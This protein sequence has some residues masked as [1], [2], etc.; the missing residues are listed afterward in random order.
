MS[1]GVNLA[2]EQQ[3][4]IVQGLNQ[5]LDW[6]A[7]AIEYRLT[8]YFQATETGDILVQVPAPPLSG[9]Y[10]QLLRPYSLEDAE[11][12]LLILALAPHLRPEILDTFFVK[13]TNLDRPF[14]EFGGLTSS[15]HQGFLPTA[16][17][18]AFLLA[19]TDLNGRLRTMALLR[20]Q[21]ALRRLQLL[22]L[23]HPAGHEP[24]L[25]ASLCVS[26]D[27][28]QL[29]ITG[30]RNMP[31]YNMQFPAKRLQSLLSWNDLILPV[32]VMQE[33]EHILGWLQHQQQIMGHWQLSRNISP[34]YR[35]LFYGPP[36]TGKTLTAT[37]IGQRA[38]A[39]VY[40]IDLSSLVSKYI[41][42][43]EKNLSTLFDQA[44]ARNW[45][46]FFDEADALFGKRTA[47]HSSHDRYANQE[48][49]YLLQRIEDFPGMVILA[50]NLKV[51][52]DEAFARRFQ[53]LLYFPLPE[54]NERLR[55]WQQ[56]LSGPVQLAQDV[57]IRQLAFEHEVSGGAIT[58][59]V[60]YA[61]I[62]ALQQ[63]SERIRAEDLLQGINR[64]KRKEG[65]MV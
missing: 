31:D 45:I 53:S 50:S 7:R 23:Q 63:G 6:L 9:D 18:A 12:L 2:H 59:I 60:R 4:D 33:V 38:K 5:E 32:P 1:S 16:Q 58:N 42:E 51:N 44:Q 15:Q 49:S 14:T 47:T 56:I 19:G 22:H 13:N 62:R 28:L 24:F 64:E 21:R 30:S 61:A 43:T 52:I 35:S 37:L 3:Q 25:S 55:L 54:A 57:D 26:A 48:V 27:W 8:H 46:L 36:G 29:L 10:G 20:P 11:R 39:D 65:S 40:R 41:G 34:G 17:T